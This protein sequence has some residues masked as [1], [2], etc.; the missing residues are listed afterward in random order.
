MAPL[1]PVE[2]LS[3]LHDPGTRRDLGCSAVGSG[4]IGWQKLEW[5]RCGLRNRRGVGLIRQ[6]ACY[7][8]KRYS[9]AAGPHGKRGCPAQLAAVGAD[10]WG[11]AKRIVRWLRPIRVA[12]RP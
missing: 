1:G 10:T 3:V 5:C 12:R 7:A 6:Y 9:G 2:R 11:V 8:A 4:S